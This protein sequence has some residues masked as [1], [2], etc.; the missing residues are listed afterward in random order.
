MP[1]MKCPVSGK[2]C[3]YY[4]S[5]VGSQNPDSFACHHLL[6]TDHARRRGKDGECLSWR[7]NR[8]GRPKAHKV[9]HLFPTGASTMDGYKIYERIW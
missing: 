9:W 4:R 1:N 7:A 3:Y 6:E 2:P 5:L 8:R